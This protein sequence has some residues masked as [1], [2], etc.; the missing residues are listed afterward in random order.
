M[1]TAADFNNSALGM[2]PYTLTFQNNKDEKRY[3][4]LVVTSNLGYLRLVY[5]VLL[6]IFAGYTAGAAGVNHDYR[7][8]IVRVAF[9]FAFAV[10]GLILCT[11]TIHMRYHSVAYFV[12]RNLTV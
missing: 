5:Y 4:R 10:M 1:L 7:L 11:R 12:K 3:R 6:L 8:W 9:I 2:N